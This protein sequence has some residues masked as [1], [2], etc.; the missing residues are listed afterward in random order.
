MCIRDSILVQVVPYDALVHGDRL[1]LC[2]YWY[3]VRTFRDYD[4]VAVSRLSAVQLGLL[5]SDVGGHRDASLQLR[6]VLDSVPLVL[7]VPA[8]DRDGGSQRHHATRRTSLNE[9]T[10]DQ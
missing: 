2:E 1:H 7:P 3:V 10:N 4:H 5:Y 6:P 8:G 9:T